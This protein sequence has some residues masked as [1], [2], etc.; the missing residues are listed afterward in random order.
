MKKITRTHDRG[1]SYVPFV[2]AIELKAAGFDWPCK[3]NYQLKKGEN[4][5]DAPRLTLSEAMGYMD[6]NHFH[7]IDDI[8]SAPTIEMAER[9]LSQNFDVN[10]SVIPMVKHDGKWGS[11][12]LFSSI[13]RGIWGYSY[14]LKMFDTRD[15]A[16]AEALKRAL[17][18][19][20]SIKDVHREVNELLDLFINRIEQKEP[21]GKKRPKDEPLHPLRQ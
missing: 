8:V 9:W 4:E 16:L 20:T 1:E 6:F 17:Y 12:L 18:E 3:A 11:F 2:T 15:E 7:G 13:K 21:D 5:G 10:P 19:A 14:E